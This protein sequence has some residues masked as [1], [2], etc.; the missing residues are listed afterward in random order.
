[1]QRRGL[2]K[3]QWAPKASAITGTVLYFFIVGVFVYTIYEYMQMEEFL[4][5]LPEGTSVSDVWPEMIAGT[6]TV[7]SPMLIGIVLNWIGALKKNRPLLIVAAVFYM[8]NM[9]L[10]FA[11]LI[12]CMPPMIL[13]IV[14]FYQLGKAPSLRQPR[15]G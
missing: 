4:L 8:L 6:L 15:L 9:P 7:S 1:M 3:S 13:A 11:F 12:C 5:T 2:V 10:H 14:A